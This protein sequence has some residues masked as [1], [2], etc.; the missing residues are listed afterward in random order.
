VFH[1]LEHHLDHHSEHQGEL[2]M[3][4]PALYLE[5]VRA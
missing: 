2:R 1:E 5:A 3:T 4:V